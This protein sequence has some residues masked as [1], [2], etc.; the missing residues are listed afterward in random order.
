[1]GGKIFK[2][3]Y[4]QLLLKS[5]EYISEKRKNYTEFNSLICWYWDN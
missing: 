1:M 2:N 3:L 5:R 4:K